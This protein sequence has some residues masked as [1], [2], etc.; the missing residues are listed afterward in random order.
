ME[1]R[2]NN[3]GQNEKELSFEL[4]CGSRSVALGHRCPSESPESPAKTQIYWCNSDAIR[5]GSERSPQK[6]LPYTRLVLLPHKVNPPQ[7]GRIAAE[8]ANCERREGPWA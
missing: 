7:W 5:G 2:N 8:K 1:M 4:S 6:S 3:T